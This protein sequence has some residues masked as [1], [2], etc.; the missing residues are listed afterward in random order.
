ML[1]IINFLVYIGRNL[2]NAATLSELRGR[3]FHGE[4]CT[5]DNSVIIPL[6][7]VNASCSIS[8]AALVE[9]SV[10]SAIFW[11]IYW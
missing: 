11:Y 4:R 1:Y 8:L 7:N 5:S 3:N 10:N 6:S 2:T 9:I